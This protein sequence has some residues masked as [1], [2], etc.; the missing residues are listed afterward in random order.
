MA[1]ALETTFEQTVHPNLDQTNFNRWRTQRQTLANLLT[2]LKPL[3]A[4]K[5]RL[6]PISRKKKIFDCCRP[7]SS[8]NSLRIVMRNGNQ[9]TPETSPRSPSLARRAPSPRRDPNSTNR[10]SSLDLPPR[11]PSLDAHSPQARRDSHSL[12]F[13]QMVRTNARITPREGLNIQRSL[14][15]RTLQYSNAEEQVTTPLPHVRIDDGRNQLF[16]EIRDPAPSNLLSLNERDLLVAPR[17]HQQQQQQRQQQRPSRRIQITT[18]QT[19]I[20]L[21]Y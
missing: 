9:T 6:Y 1:I 16:E 7:L 18:L 21:S 8:T 12:I 13:N 14:D 10:Q 4:R 15:P 3:R 11:P 2:R 5:L 19:P 20:S 17:H